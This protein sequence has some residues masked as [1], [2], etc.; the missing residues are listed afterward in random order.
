MPRK[1][2]LL[3]LILTLTLLTTNSKSCNSK[4]TNSNSLNSIVTESFIDEADTRQ[5]VYTPKIGMLFRTV[6]ILL[7]DDNFVEGDE[8]FS[9]IFSPENG[10]DRFNG[11]NVVNVTIT[12]DESEKLLNGVKICYDWS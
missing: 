7:K 9:V 5:L 2:Y 11:T 12:D 6:V 3:T 10:L 8:K 1:Y 4:S